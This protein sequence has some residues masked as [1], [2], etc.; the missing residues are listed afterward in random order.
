MVFI[1]RF[2]KLKLLL[3]C[4]DKSINLHKHS[5]FKKTESHSDGIFHN[6]SRIISFNKSSDGTKVA[7]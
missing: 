7:Q 3:I 4:Y 6:N 2:F 5:F 1:F